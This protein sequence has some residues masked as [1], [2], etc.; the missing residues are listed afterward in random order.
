VGA[1]S[2]LRLLGRDPA[3][4][5]P[6]KRP[7]DT[8]AR[9]PYG[10]GQGRGG[11]AR[12]APSFVGLGRANTEA[13]DLENGNE[14]TTFTGESGMDSCAVAP[15]GPTI[16]ACARFRVHF[17][18]IVEADPSKLESARQRFSSCALRSKPDLQLIPEIHYK[19]LESVRPLRRGFFTHFCSI[20]TTWF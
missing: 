13:W 7:I 16:I 2:R 10:V 3:A 18:Q 5:G 12:W 17:L 8:D 11:D 9:R 6:G 15:D 19:F 14:I 20:Y 1:P 4:A